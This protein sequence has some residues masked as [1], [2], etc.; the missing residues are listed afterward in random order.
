MSSVETFDLCAIEEDL[1]FHRGDTFVWE[2]VYK[3]ENGNVVDITGFSFVL[4]VD[5]RANPDDA[6]TNIFQAT[7][8]VP[9]G[10]DGRLLFQFSVANWT[11]YTTAIGDPPNFAFYDMQ[12]TDT[13]ADLRTIRFGKFRVKQDKTK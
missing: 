2:R 5:S 8:T 3:D 7:A 13:S 11:A 6:S 1:C 12:Q 4:T 10:T 9:V